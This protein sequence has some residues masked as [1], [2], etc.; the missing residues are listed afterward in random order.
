MK[1]RLLILHFF[2]LA[3]VISSSY[4]HAEPKT[5]QKSVHTCFSNF[6]NLYFQKSTTDFFAVGNSFKITDAVNTFDQRGYSWKQYPIFPV[7]LQNPFTIPGTTILV[8]ERSVTPTFS[9]HFFHFLEHLLGIWNFGGEENRDHVGLVVLAQNGLITSHNW[10]GANDVTYHLIKAAF[11]KAEI[12]QWSDF[13]EQSPSEVLRFENVI[14]S[15]RSME[16]LRKEPY[17]TERMLGGYFQFLTKSS[18][19]RLASSIWDYCEVRKNP[20]DKTRVTYVQRSHNRQFKSDCEKELINKIRALPNVEL[21][22]VD[23]APISFREQVQIVA[24]TDVLLGVH[25]NGLSHAL[26]LPEGAALIEIFP[27]NSFKVEYRIITKARGLDYFGWIDEA[28]WISDRTAETIGSHGNPYVSDFN[29]NVDA[30]VDVIRSRVH[31]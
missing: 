28:G 12:K 18:L 3:A 2:A 30:I 6:K 4:I 24:N 15:D 22:I 5:E 19:D 11:P 25:G 7:R 8:L 31:P 9:A 17:P 23:F 21:S 1:I 20:S 14:I 13:V 10:K 16:H 27:K 29:I 26:L